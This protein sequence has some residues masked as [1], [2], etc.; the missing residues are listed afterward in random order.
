M[1]AL[2]KNTVEPRIWQL[3]SN[4]MDM[5]ELS[6]FALV[7][8]TNLS[9]RYGHRISTDLDLFCNEPFEKEEVIEAIYKKMPH[10]IKL[11]E[12]KQ[13]VW[14]MIDN[15]KVDMI[16]Y[17]YRYIKGIELIDNIRF[18]SIEDI[19]PMKLEAMATRGVKKDFWDIA[20]LLNHFSLTQMLDYYQFKYPQSDPGH[21]LR[22][23][24]YFV[25]AEPDANP[26]DLQG[27]TWEQ[28]KTTMQKTVNDYIKRQSK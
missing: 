22:A 4:L 6:N 5:P 24:T 10:T 15:I 14:L 3:L 21:V 16:L 12:R 17:Q 11:G 27:I 23:M 7:G 19:I 18:L 9:L 25:D 13:T 8:G 20:Q 28:V 26:I 2:F 1:S